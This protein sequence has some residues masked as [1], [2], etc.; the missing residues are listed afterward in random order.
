[1]I[2]HHATRVRDKSIAADPGRLLDAARE[3]SDLARG[4][5]IRQSGD[6]KD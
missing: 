4:W 5:P 3:T 1:M 2:Y 6:C